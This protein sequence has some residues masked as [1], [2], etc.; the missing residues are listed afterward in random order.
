MHRSSGTTAVVERDLIPP[1]NAADPDGAHAQ[2]HLAD[3]WGPLPGWSAGRTLLACY[4]TF[5][6]Y[7]E[8]HAVVDAY[9]TP[10]KDL[11]GL[12]LVDRPWLH[13]T[14][15]GLAF[16]DEVDPS[17]TPDRFAGSVAHRLAAIAPI[18]VATTEPV[19]GAE[20]VYLR[21]RPAEG[22]DAAREVIRGAGR[23]VLGGRDLN[24]LPGQD[25]AYDPHLSIAYANRAVPAADI[26]ARLASV[27]HAP[28]GFEVTA[29]SVVLLR[30]DDVDRRWHWTDAR[31][32]EL[33]GAG[34]R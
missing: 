6:G 29:L 15:Q 33:G 11:P 9:Q 22:L 3:H 16:T 32:V 30:R 25:A 27:T 13:T 24:V 1:P 5:T 20:G 10:L 34:S 31:H 18:Q 7:P 4:V 26:R 8:V 2:P 28:V 21:L 19:I 23:D 12:D 17:C 14:V